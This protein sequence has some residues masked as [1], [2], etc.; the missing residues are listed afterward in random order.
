MTPT[1]WLDAQFS[2][3]SNQL[4]R[5]GRVGRAPTAIVENR[6]SDGNRNKTSDP[7]HL[8]LDPVVRVRGSPSYLS[9][10]LTVLAFNSHYNR[11]S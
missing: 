5:S 10:L 7:T 1:N 3:A 2:R 9:G 6:G 11:V 8:G 4:V